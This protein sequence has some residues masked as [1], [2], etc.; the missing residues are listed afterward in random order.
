MVCIGCQ[1]SVESGK[2]RYFDEIEAILSFLRSGAQTPQLVLDEPFSGTNT[3]ERIAAAKAVLAALN[4]H[5]VVLATTHDVELQ[6]LLVER[7]GLYHFLE[8]PDLAALFD[9][10]LCSGPC[11]EGNALRLLAR[12]GFPAGIVGE[13]MAYLAIRGTVAET[14]SRRCSIRVRTSR[15]NVSGPRIIP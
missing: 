5:S 3:T 1:P 15:R 6:G 2:S 12:I 10:R 7:A 11:I 4:L 13:A 14:N 9:G 8:R